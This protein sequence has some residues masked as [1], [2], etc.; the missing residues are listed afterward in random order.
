MSIILILALLTLIFYTY[1]SHD[2][3]NRDLKTIF[4]LRAKIGELRTV[5]F[6]YALYREERPKI[7]TQA[8]LRAL[9]PLFE[10]LRTSSILQT[11]ASL[12]LWQ[13]VLDRFNECEVNFSFLLKKAPNLLQEERERQMVNL[14]LLR[15]AA[16]ADAVENLM[17]PLRVKELE[18]H[19]SILLTIGFT[20]LVLLSLPATILV[21]LQFS[22]LKPLTILTET[23]KKIGRNNHSFRFNNQDINE[24][25]QLSKAF[26]QMLD[27]IHTKEEQLYAI[28]NNTDTVIFIKDIEGR[29]L[30]V[31]HLYEKLFH[32]SNAEIKGK[33]DFDIFPRAIA[34]KLRANDK[35]ILE[36]LTSQK[37]E[38]RVP[39]D[40]GIHTYISVKFIW[41]GE[42][43]KT[44]G[45][46]G[47]ATDITERKQTE[48][49]LIQSEA[50]LRAIL[51]NVPYLVW[52]KDIKGYLVA[53]NKAFLQVTEYEE[54]RD[55]LGKTD[56]EIL[57]QALAEKCCSEDIEVMATCQQKLIEQVIT[58]KN[59][60]IRW[61]EIYKAPIL[62]DKGQLLGTTGFARDITDYKRYIGE[63]R[64]AQ[65]LAQEISTAKSNFLANMSHEIRT[66]MSAI[67]GLSELALYQSLSP[68]VRDYLEKILLSS[69]SLLGILNDILD[70][71]KIEAGRMT[72]EYAPFRLDEL[73]NI[74]SNLFILRAEEKS[75]NFSIEVTPETPNQLVGDILRLQQVLSNL[76]GNAIK[77][78]E[79]GHVSLQIACQVV[80][81]SQAKLVFKVEDTGIGMSEETVAH[82]FQSFTQADGSISR[83]FGGTG[84]GLTI[85]RDLLLLMGSDFTVE[86]TFGQGS[87]FIFELPFGVAASI[88]LDAKKQKSFAKK[89]FD[90]YRHHLTGSR[91]LVVEDN[92]I[93]QQIIRELLIWWRV[94]VEIANH[95]QEA[96]DCLLS[97]G[98]FDTVLMDIHMPTMDGLV[99]TRRIRQIETLAALPI[100]ALTAGV[101]TNE[102]ELAL[103]AGMNA[104]IGKPIN[105]EEL[106]EMLLH[107]VPARMNVATAL[108]PPSQPS[109]PL[110][111]FPSNDNFSGVRNIPENSSDSKENF[112]VLTVLAQKLQILLTEMDLIPDELLTELALAIPEKHQ[113]LYKIFQH[114]VDQFDYKKAH[115]VLEQLVHSV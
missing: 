17:Q 42:K 88:R 44:Y 73:L 15:S 114:H 9:P 56:F 11:E 66:P 113:T 95:G 83:R 105:P 39:H 78:T 40:D 112:Q 85:S 115:I 70:Y 75:L 26:D 41:Y 46:C 47:I 19:R 51:D 65:E 20:T 25:G 81:H 21:L 96:L 100:I 104:F 48:E 82:L 1:E 14:F 62:D 72:I 59:G 33:T 4:L 18:V 109:I 108:S 6:E 31:N 52:Q 111:P 60:D 64:K 93:N 61:L 58:G 102:R 86:S 57:P 10:R 12:A 80:E 50:S 97:K 2:K 79:Y 91:I 54:S 38:E 84:L 103:A 7:Q 28:L 22:V 92:T 23:I 35:K 87:T 98:N 5:G 68:K 55:V 27:D 37:I 53:V 24:F 36:S 106:G 69:K 34:E 77:F 67:I 101:T 94:I 8:T 30:L 43:G 90:A 49:K 32:I 16:L 71:S 76:L 45:V 63:L 13:N 89:S 107:W 29:Y 110:V 3:M 99:A 74:L